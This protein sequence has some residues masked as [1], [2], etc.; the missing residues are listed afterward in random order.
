MTDAERS[1]RELEFKQRFEDQ[2]PEFARMCADSVEEVIFHQDAFAA[3]YQEHEFSLLGRA[4][5]YAELLG[6]NVHVVGRN[7]PTLGGQSIH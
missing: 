5:K 1:Q 7:A 6:K 2:L 3:D 4:I